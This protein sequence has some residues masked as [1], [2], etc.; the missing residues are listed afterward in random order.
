MK[1]SYPSLRRPSVKDADAF[2]VEVNAAEV[3][4]VKVDFSQQA[5]LLS[6]QL[7]TQSAKHLKN[8]FFGSEISL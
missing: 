2:S 4:E 3:C 6:F 8:L 1:N 7:N 5:M